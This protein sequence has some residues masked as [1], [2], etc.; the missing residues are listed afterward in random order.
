[1]LDQGVSKVLGEK[2]APTQTLQVG[3]TRQEL[4]NSF[5]KAELT[6]QGLQRQRETLY[7]QQAGYKLQARYIPALEQ[8]LREL[9]RELKA[10]ESTYQSLLN[11]LQE[12]Q[13][14]ENQ[15][16]PTVQIIEPASKP[17]FPILPN[18][19]VDLLRSAIAAALFAAALVFLLEKLDR[20]VKSTDDVQLV[21]PYT[22]LGTIP[23]FGRGRS[24]HVQLPTLQEAFSSVSESYRMLQANLKFVRFDDSPVRTLVVTSALPGEG[25]STTVANLAVVL[26]EMGHRVLLIDADLRKPSQ[27]RIWEVANATG[28]TDTLAKPIDSFTDEVLPVH[29]VA[30]NLDLIT[31]GTMTPNPLVILDSQ[32]TRQLLGTQSCN[33]DYILIDSPPLNVVGD[34]RVLGQ[35]VHGILLVARPEVL[36]KDNARVARE[37]LR[38]SNSNVLGMVINGVISMNEKYSYYNYS[39]YGE[40]INKNG[41]GQVLDLKEVVRNVSSD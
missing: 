21:Y 29:R 14:T 33:Y 16:I 17:D 10:A 6:R 8:R 28:L 12:V 40:T 22:V 27:H 26:G 30:N 32:Q 36:D 34:A 37:S 19:Q 41:N 24:H 23:A 18:H 31:S 2:N 13:V 5:I 20:K 4:L 25:K 3:G 35:I 11:K 1:L 39:S 9:D 15:T 7:A 38:H